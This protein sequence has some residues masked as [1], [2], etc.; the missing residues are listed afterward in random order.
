MTSDEG[1][2]VRV[3]IIG[4]GLIGTS[5]G[6]G[7]RAIGWPVTIHDANEDAQKL[8]RGLG[9]GGSLSDTTDPRNVDP[10]LIIVAVPPSATVSELLTALRRWPEAIVT[11]VA[12]IKAPFAAAVEHA[13]LATRY[14][15][16]HPMAGR[17]LSGP[18]A[19][20]GDL[21]RA[22][23]WVLC[24][25]GAASE[26]VALV[27][28]LAEALGAD[29]I[30]TN[31]SAHDAAVAR[32]S[33][34]PQVVASAVAAALVSLAPCDIALAGQ[35]LRDVTRIAGSEPGMWADIARMNET[36]LKE[37]L[38]GIIDDLAAVRDAEDIGEALA[39]LIERGGRE[40]ARIPGK[41]GT[42]H[43]DWTP[44]TVIVPDEPGQLLRLLTDVASLKINVED[45]AIEHSPKQVVG[46]V[47][48]SVDPARAE[49]LISALGARGW[50]VAS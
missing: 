1:T 12:S 2:P 40:V 14:V 32:V 48:L 43:R 37:T 19:A 24:P 27:R 9:A 49:E 30:V 39:N 41:H 45:L 3:H 5:I 21:F 23:P 4:A 34:A 36:N 26:A 18:L 33:H 46:L 22:R 17:E 10:D 20:Q 47:A 29:V 44:V 11:D 15:G 8:A 35:G 16:S 42:R 38:E 28:R 6:V 50:E 7:L 31:A 13:G 25:D